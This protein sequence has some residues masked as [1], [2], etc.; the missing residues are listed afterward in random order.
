[1]S[2]KV[3]TPKQISEAGLHGMFYHTDPASLVVHTSHV[4]IDGAGGTA[5]IRYE[6]PVPVTIKA[7]EKESED[8]VDWIRFNFDEH[9]VDLHIEASKDKRE[10]RIR[11]TVGTGETYDVPVTQDWPQDRGFSLTTSPVVALAA[12]DTFTNIWV[13]TNEHWTLDCGESWITYDKT[14]GHGSCQIFVT[15]EENTT[16][17]TR[18]GFIK[19]TGS[20]KKEIVEIRQAGATE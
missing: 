16:P 3:L 5:F 12:T 7:I 10:A 19:I 11:F 14:Y 13:Q 1:M 6:S 18:Y 17:T 4:E 15:L 9:G 20:G 8:A 2:D